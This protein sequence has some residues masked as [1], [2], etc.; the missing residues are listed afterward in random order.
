[1][2]LQGSDRR[3]RDGSRDN[4][5]PSSKRRRTGNSELEE[6]K[7][8]GSKHVTT[9]TTRACDL[10]RAKKNRCDG[11][12]PTCQPCATA[13][14]DCTYGT[15]SKKR[16]FPTGYVRILEALWALVFKT[17]PGS[18]ETTLEL[19]RDAHILYDDDEK[20]TLGSTNIGQ[21]ESLRQIWEKS[22]VRQEI[23]R[24]V[25]EI[26]HNQKL[27]SHPQRAIENWAST[28]R[29]APLTGRAD[30]SSWVAPVAQPTGHDESMSGAP[31]PPNISTGLPLNGCVV[32]S[33]SLH[34]GYH[35][36]FV[37]D[38]DRTPLSNQERSVGFDTG[39]VETQPIL[40]TDAWTLLEI[41][42]KY[43]NC[44]FPTIPKH[45]VV[46][47][48][49]SYQEGGPCC[50]QAEAALLWAVFAMASVQRGVAE[51]DANGQSSYHYYS[52]ARDMVLKGDGTY[53]LGHIQALLLLAMFNMAEGKWGAAFLL[54]GNAVRIILL[55]QESYPADLGLDG[56]RREAVE[57]PK[58][59]LLGAFVLETIIAARIHAVPHLRSG[60]IRSAIDFDENGP[61][62]WDQWSNVQVDTDPGPGIR[63]L[64]KPIRALS[65]FKEYV[66]LLTVFN[67]IVCGS[68]RTSDGQDHREKWSRSLDSWLSQ[69]PRHCNFVATRDLPLT[70]L[71]VAPP[72]ANLCIMYDTVISY[73][74]FAPGSV[75]GSQ[76]GRSIPAFPQPAL[77]ARSVYAQAF[78][79][80]VWRGVLDMHEN[81][82]A[83]AH[84]RGG[85][86]GPGEDQRNPTSNLQVATA[87]I[88]P[89]SGTGNHALTGDA[90]TRNPAAVG[91]TA[92]APL[93][94]RTYPS[95]METQSA[96]LDPYRVS[97]TERALNIGSNSSLSDIPL[98]GVSNPF[99]VHAQRSAMQVSDSSGQETGMD[100]SLFDNYDDAQAVESLLEELS[101]TQDAEWNTMSSQFMY[102]LGFYDSEP[103]LS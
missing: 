33:N 26:E 75:S 19:L 82:Y 4:V 102:N 46:R 59:L 50:G 93:I 13:G 70:P 31:G 99:P 21:D 90:Y 91:G 17:V 74:Q 7:V 24:M 101:S 20:V 29:T 14:H 61:E 55:R 2:E 34:K 35:L 84:E 8:D 10:C 56:L 87:P 65:T 3:Q 78:G 77:R 45:D 49:S 64:P 98:S 85:S 63:L 96:L 81:A 54:V 95:G 39:T 23:D 60:D 94:D 41:Y 72:V 89:D 76:T 92:S 40:P 58:R 62:E 43:N 51:T 48:L 27:G 11:G 9:R 103:P 12:Q 100:Q 86:K 97:G 30:F 15:L 22:P 1:M 5:L 66:K 37:G 53:F 67:D 32:K 36:D 47:I 28:T 42:F 52:L 80:F 71:D 69:L 79:S 6:R 73:L 44:W 25:A 38:G 68:Q 57:I 83:K 88:Y 16:G 18:E